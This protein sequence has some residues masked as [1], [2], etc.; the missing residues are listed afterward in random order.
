MA[1]IFSEDSKVM[2]FLAGISDILFLGF[3]WLIFSV[4]VVT[5]GAS[6]TATY[7]T[8]VKG[9]RKKRGYIFKN[10][11]KS[12]KMNFKQATLMWLFM[13]VVGALIGYDIFIMTS[14]VVNIPSAIK[15]IILVVTVILA[16]TTSFAF[17]L[18]S[19]FDNTNVNIF[20][21]SFAISIAKFPRA[22]IMVVVSL[23]PI[24]ILFMPQYLPF[25]ILF[26]FSVPAWICAI[27]YNDVFKRL[28]EIVY[29]AER[30]ANPEAFAVNPEDDDVCIFK[31]LPLEDEDQQL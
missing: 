25:F 16:L 27:L 9:I 17:P 22:V 14:T 4:P 13:L 20:K 5:I 21:N 2:A 19:K 24:A 30:E 1:K 12:F 31:D 8:M 29:E 18:L 23:A 6:T 26:G 7:Y 3:L 11:W 10:F 28:E 15:V